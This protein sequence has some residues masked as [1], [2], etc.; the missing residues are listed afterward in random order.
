MA[1]PKKVAPKRK[2][3][4]RAVVAPAVTEKTLG[5]SIIEQ[6]IQ[7]ND[8]LAA[9]VIVLK[10]RQALTPAAAEVEK[11]IAEV[12]QVE[13]ATPAEVAAAMAPKERQRRRT[14]AEMEA[15]RAADAEAN[16]LA[17]FSDTAA[18]TVLTQGAEATP[19]HLPFPKAC[20][21]GVREDLPPH[22]HSHG[23]PIHG[24]KKLA[25]T[26]GSSV[27]GAT[28]VVEKQPAAVQPAPPAAAP[29]ALTMDDIRGVAI[30]YAG[31]HGKEKLAEVL[32][33]FKSEKLSAVAPTDYPALMSALQAGV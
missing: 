10:D 15:A 12:A 11:V 8:T 29:T 1:R 31:K 6:M 2:Y 13:P 23:C 27:A 22:L 20:A 18:G 25:T 19:A 3:T 9:L 17:K 24:D 26:N 16:A 21:C 28:E 7:V 5:E 32:S 14:K 30:A 33:K 4:R